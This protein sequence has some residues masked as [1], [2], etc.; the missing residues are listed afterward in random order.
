MHV[1]SVSPCTRCGSGLLLF[2]SAA[3]L[4]HVHVCAQIYFMIFI[5][6][7]LIYI[8]IKF[9]DAVKPSMKDSLKKLYTG[10]TGHDGTTLAWNA[11]M[12][13][14]FS[15]AKHAEEYKTFFSHLDK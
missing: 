2:V 1:W 13:L 6:L 9:D 11:I 4:Q 14:V 15:I 10:D 3:I 12:G 5:L 8:F 7:Y